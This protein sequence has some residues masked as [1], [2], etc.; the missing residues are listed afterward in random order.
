MPYIGQ[1][2]STGE[3][4]NFKI[5][6]SISSYT[7]TFN[8]SSSGVV[9]VADNTLTFLSHRFITGQRIT[10]STSG[11]AIGGLVISTAY[12]VIKN[13]QNTIK[14]AST[15]ANANNN[16]AIDL[17]AL[18]TGTT[19]TL[20]VAFDSINT[21]FKASFDN[22]TKALITRAGQ[23]QI[24][25]NGVIQQ[26]QDTTSP[27]NGFGIDLDGV[28]IFSTAPANTDIFWGNVFANNFATFDISDNT[29]DSFTGT[30]SQTNFT[31]SK[32]PANNQNILVTIDGVVQYPSDATNV[33][34]YSVSGNVLTFVG[35]PGNGSLIQVRHI[36]FA[37]ATSSSV[38]GFYG[39]TGNV[40]LTTADTVSIGAATIGTGGIGT[41]L[42]VQG[43]ARITG[44]L[45]IGNGSITFDGVNNT[46]T[47]VI[48]TNA[49]GVSTVGSL[50]IG[51]TSVISAGRQLQNI[52]SLDATTTATIE[53]AIT[54]AHNTFSDLSVSG[55]STL[56]VTSATNLTS[57][58]LNVSGISTLGSATASSLVVSGVSTL[59][60]A[61][62]SSLVVSG[63]STLGVTSA[64]NLTTQSLSVS[65]ISTFTN[66]PVLVGTATSTGTASQRLQVT[67]GAYV[68]GSVGIGTTN[69]QAALHVVGSGTTALLVSGNA[70]I[71]GILTVGTS[72]LTF[73]G[74]SNVITG[75]STISGSF[76][77]AKPNLS[78]ISS[79]ISSTAVDVFVYDTRKDSDGG[80]WRKRTQNTSWYNE[81]LNTATRGARK[82]F[83]AVAVIVATSSSVT[84][85]DGDDPDMPMW[86]V[87][88][89]T[90]GSM[91][92]YNSLTCVFMLNG[93]MWVGS[94]SGNSVFWINFLKDTSRWITGSTSY[95]GYFIKGYI[96]KRN[97]SGDNYYNNVAGSSNITIVSSYIND[98][99]M[100]VLPN[101]PID[102]ATGLPVPTIA[103]ATDGGVSIIKDDGTV[104]NWLT[105]VGY[106][107][108]VSISKNYEIFAG[109]GGS[110][111][112]YAWYNKTIPTS[113]S[114]NSD[115]I[116][117][118]S[119]SSTSLPRLGNN[120]NSP[121]GEKNV[122]SNDIIYFSEYA[123]ASTNNKLIILNQNTTH[124]GNSLVAY[125]TTSYNTG[126]MY[127][128]IKGAWLS[129]TSTASVTGTE[130]VTNGDFATSTLT[131]YTQLY[132]CTLSVV[133]NQLRVTSTA[134]SGY[135]EFYISISDTTKAHYFSFQF[136]AASGITQFGIY[137]GNTGYVTDANAGWSNSS[138][139]A[140]RSAGTYTLLIPPGSSTVGFVFGI[141]SVGQTWTFDNISLRKATELDRSVN[142][143]GLAVY[144]TITKTAVATG[145]NLVAYSG[146]SDSNYLKQPHNSSLEFGTGSFS[147]TVWFKSST[148]DASY[149]KGLVYLNRNGSIGE[150]FQIL[151]TPSNEIYFY[152]YGPTNDFTSTAYTGYNDGNWHQM[153]VS[154]TGTHQRVYLDGVLKETGNITT[155][156]ITDT[157]SELFIGKWYGDINPLFYW[158]GSI[159]LCRISGSIPSPTQILKIY[160]DEKVL[161]QENS[162]C[163]LYG[164]SD[165]V[166]ALAYDDTT[167]LLSVGTSSGRSDFQGLER[168]NNTTTAVT[169]AISASNGLIVEQ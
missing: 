135:C 60:I 38:T 98:V 50:S 161:F 14:L 41:S 120:G 16:V 86:M 102:A 31:L 168:I 106:I 51:N 105:T 97:D 64:T 30:G 43:N 117:G 22:G 110:I 55:I 93:E 20:I 134:S 152:I 12:F 91:L 76:N 48:N 156:S 136:V 13:D 9:S 141:A 116:F 153:S 103:V 148:A 82:D 27:T 149:Y 24:S 142:N 65:G 129:D 6:D 133:S 73:D 69:P 46:I 79:S 94:N 10:Y 112:Y 39:R 125:A 109:G 108:Q 42:L 25:I 92:R 4:N 89:T 131:S 115:A 67:G 5:L 26:P 155:G 83:P 147:Y 61:T 19:H 100:T 36:G 143:R 17:T 126:W 144:G 53:S 66:G 104:V 1:I 128:D 29:V 15:F 95:G 169:T 58:Q 118:T 119:Y 130:L 127:G 70:R 72:S 80:A 62:A 84:I 150:G 162:Q 138:Y 75:L 77:F 101:A 56:G 160:N 47:G 88:N 151:L 167:K 68:S 81:T 11:T 34:A 33:R 85:Y 159:A 154:S 2:P 35:A 21:K 40:G 32:I 158:R 107:I 28:I 157:S 52:A 63:I 145:S 45:T 99:A 23:L 18:G 139:T 54:N 146:F 111:A 165:A 37:G 163:T 59:G 114:N 78:G 124:F 96:S 74:N 113:S 166:T 137:A 3:N 7:E 132:N 122:F 164:A 121:V 44:I 71:T 140:S 87:F 57:Q 123:G 49:T 8:G 90:S